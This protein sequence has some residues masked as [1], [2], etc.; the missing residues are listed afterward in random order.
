MFTYGTGE[1]CAKSYSMMSEYPGNAGDWESLYS[2]PSAELFG[3][4]N[5]YLKSVRLG[6]SIVVSISENM[7]DLEKISAEIIEVL[8]GKSK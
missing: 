6:R 1:A 2:N 8:T 5:D 7:M 4:R 3:L